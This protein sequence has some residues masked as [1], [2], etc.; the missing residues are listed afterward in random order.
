MAPRGIGPPAGQQ[1]EPLI[2][3][4]GDFRRAQRRHPRGGELDRQR[5][6][7]QPPA[8]LTDGGDVSG[9]QGEV[10]AHGRRA[11]DEQGHRIAGPGGGHARVRGRQRQRPQPEDLLTVH[12]QRLP[13]RGQ[14]T[15]PPAAAQDAGCQDSR[16]AQQVLAIVEHHQRVFGAQELYDA[17]GRGQARPRAH[18]QG[19]RDGLRHRLF[20]NGGVE[21]AQPRPVA[22]GRQLVGGGVQRQTR[23]ADPAGADHRH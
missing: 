1:P 3:Q 6:P 11:L 9:T 4:P 2:E 18:P 16:C 22:E 14:E 12:A 21:L 23:L 19:G 5:D 17:T 20:V 13:A 15:H 10:A 7:I 8:D